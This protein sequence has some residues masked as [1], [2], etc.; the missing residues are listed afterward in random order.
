MS[1]H[2]TTFSLDIATVNT[3][4]HL[5][6]HWNT[7]QA[8]VIRRAVSAAAEQALVKITPQQAI[9]Q[10]RGGAVEMTV[11]SLECLVKEA[12]KS[13]LEADKHRI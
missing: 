11:H 7:S 12:R 13:R 4:K 6:L 2:R 1:A 3:L 8:G 10:F 5:A 9:E